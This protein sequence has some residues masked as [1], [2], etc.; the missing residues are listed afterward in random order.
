VWIFTKKKYLTHFGVQYFCIL[1]N[2]IPNGEYQGEKIVEIM[3]GWI[4][5][6]KIKL[7]IKNQKEKKNLEWFV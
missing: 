3:F 4:K 2:S 1:S 7:K 6:Y 5:G